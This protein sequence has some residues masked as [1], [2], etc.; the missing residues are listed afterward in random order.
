MLV[1]TCRCA[2]SLATP[3]ALAAATTRLTRTGLLATRTRAVEALT[4]A[5]CFMSDKTGR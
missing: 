1:V 4:R 3:A 5:D 2:L